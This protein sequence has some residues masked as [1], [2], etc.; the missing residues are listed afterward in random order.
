MTTNQLPTLPVCRECGHTSHWLGD[1]ILEAHGMSVSQYLAK[2]EGAETISQEAYD[3]MLSRRKTRNHPTK[4]EDL[5]IKFGGLEFDVNYE[6]PADACAPENPYYRFPTQG[7]AKEACFNAVLGL[8]RG[9]SQFVWGCAG[10]GKDAFFQR[11]SELTRTPCKVIQVNPDLDIS[12]ILFSHEIC[13]VKGSYYKEGVLLKAL[14]DGY[15][16]ESGKRIPYLIILTDIDRATPQQG[17]HLRMV[18]DSVQGRI[19]TPDGGVEKVLKGS[20]IVATANSTGNGAIGGRYASSQVMDSSILSRFTYTWEFKTLSWKDEEIVVRSK[21]PILARHCEEIFTAVGKT[22]EV[23]RKAT[24]RGD[25]EMEFGH[26]ELSGWMDF[27]ECLAEY[28]LKR[29]RKIRTHILKESFQVVLQALDSDMRDAVTQM[30]DTH[31]RGGLV[32]Q[33]D[34]SHI[35]DGELHSF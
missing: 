24:E 15:V 6:V 29:G 14:R 22:T 31:I 11:F 9:V 12:K 10:T 28:D 8:M 17:E 25:L 19:Q 4:R 27:A 21:F 18:L 32:N 23:I 2:H 26:R 33:G 5:S 3:A 7:K 35:G 20:R 34:T 13:P 1:H 30:V 16:T